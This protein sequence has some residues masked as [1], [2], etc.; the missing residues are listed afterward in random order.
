ME[1]HRE[2]EVTEG[3]KQN[4]THLLSQS[5]SHPDF[6]GGGGEMGARI[7][8]KD[9]SSTPLGPV[10][11]WPQSLKTVVRIMLT[12][13]QP[14][15][16]GW[17][18]EL[19]KLYNDPYKAIVGGKH[20]DALGQPAAVVW[21]EIWEELEPRL[22]T[23]LTKNIGTYDESLLLIMERYGYEEETYYTFSY[24]PI[25]ADQGG[26]GGIIC[27][28]TDDTQR[29]IGERQVKLLRT[30]AAE[31]GDA[32][33]VEQA[34]YLSARSLEHNAYDLPFAMIYLLDQ[35]QQMITLAGITGMQRGHPAAPERM[36][37][38]APGL[39]PFREVIQTQ[40]LRLIDDLAQ[41]IEDLPT[42][43]WKRA[44]RQ[45]VLVP[46]APSGQKGQAGVLVVGLNPLR[47]F[48]DGYQGFLKLV[49]GQISASIANAEAYEEER[50]RAE[51]LAEIDR[52]KTIFFSNISHEFRTPLT[53][54]LG[55]IEE[56]RDDPTTRPLNRERIESAHRNAL[57]LLKL[58]NTLLDFSRIEAGRIQANYEPTDIALYTAELVSNFRSAIE[59]AGLKLQLTLPRL[60]TAIYIDRD[61]WEKIIFNLLSNAFKFT[62]QGTIEVCLQEYHNDVQVQVR[63]TGVGIPASD[64][65]HIFERFRRVEGARS[66]SIEGSGIGLAL[67]QE[68]VK[69]HHGTI[70]VASIEGQGTTFT[71]TL[72]KGNKHLPQDRINL[73]TQLQSTAL[74]AAPYLQEMLYWLA[75]DT[76]PAS[77]QKV[78]AMEHVGDFTDR[79]R[80][81]LADDNAD[82]RA[83]MQRLLSDQFEVEAVA[84][85]LLALQAVHARTPDLV[86]TDV[87]MPELN[88]FQLLQALKTDPGTARIPV[89][90]ISARAGEEAVIEGVQAG[91]DDYL[92]KPFSAR[93]LL[94]RVT[95]QIKTAR[96][97]YETEERLYDLFQQAPAAVVIL[98]GPT[99]VVE[100]AN[101][102]TLKIWGRTRE[103]VLHKPLFEA[104]PE[105]R[106]QGLEPLL[107]GVLKTGVPYVGE[108]LNVALDRFGT[109]HLED[110][111]FTFVYTPLRNA[112]KKIEGIMVFAY[113]VTE[114]VRARQQVEKLARQKDEFIG[115]ASHELKTPIT[116]LK[117]Y[118]QLLQRRFHQAGDES[119][120][121]LL[122]K[123]EAQVN[124]LTRLIMDLLDVTK[125]ESGHL[126]LSKTTFDMQQLVEEIVE[127][128]QRMTSKHRIV[129]E[130]AS[131]TLLFADRERIGQVLTNLLTNAIKYSPQADKVIVRTIQK[132]GILLTSVQDFGIGIAQE[133][134]AHLF[135]RFY[136]VEGDL[137]HTYPGL[138]LGLYIAAEFVKRHQG[139]IWV[140]SQEG[141]GTTITFSLPLSPTDSDSP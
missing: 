62:F 3:L 112:S 42:H 77:V 71:I 69:L 121:A 22:N 78:T 6:L 92:V 138:G 86:L 119:A 72:P 93:E 60:S 126:P 13:S 108:E 26:V 128:M 66:R 96:T 141:E 123:M 89:I 34:C 28:N 125:I 15:W 88:G 118:A 4:D 12:S 90:M 129:L 111:Y 51:A 79:P 29:I 50:K 102:I 58:V 48:D 36:A 103:Q 82:M 67:V 85:G 10:E 140:E 46:I 52:A 61:M 33:A 132:D 5:S 45:A 53:L 139:K 55:P 91:A 75:E 59:N 11:Q 80:I 106:G 54:L 83:Y 57:R 94:A 120:A 43:P 97:R 73:R 47:R 20:P 115:V 49:A 74:G 130:V 76:S 18:P 64:L 110:T 37:L 107:E 117:A 14:I 99:Y 63:D 137:Q 116:S 41:H 81:V 133:H 19:I 98:R 32:R 136:R 104:L 16:V 135:E 25:P 84:N 17:G 1:Q 39:W 30:L 56:I 44:P 7:R 21:R 70:D 68:L 114:Q 127:D 124:K 38:D 105:V 134:Q 27:A 35:E 100:L 40:E 109:G 2:V 87:M 101:P 8:A 24:S 131:S 9:W 65:P 31:T 122:H 23:A 113:E 95:T